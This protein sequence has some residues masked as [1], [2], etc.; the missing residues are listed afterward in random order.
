MVIESMLA[1]VATDLMH[2]GRGGPLPRGR[3]QW[4]SLRT[5]VDSR[6]GHTRSAMPR[7]RR[8]G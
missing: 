6:S 1:S 8:A 3:R 4:L 5:A 7:A 2:G